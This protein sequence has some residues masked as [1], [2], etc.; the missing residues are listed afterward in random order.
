[1]FQRAMTG[2]S[3]QVVALGMKNSEKNTWRQLHT[4][5]KKGNGKVVGSSRRN[6]INI[7]SRRYLSGEEGKSPYPSQAYAFGREP[8]APLEGW[9]GMYVL[10]MGLCTG[11]LVFGYGNTERESFREWAR[12]EAF[13][14]EKIIEEGGEIE[15][16]KFYSSKEGYSVESIDVMPVKRIGEDE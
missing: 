1:M 9:E 5:M 2:I 8:G 11:V 4:V 3:R 6:E 14:R 10:V 13:A 12:R 7:V 16:G 15:F